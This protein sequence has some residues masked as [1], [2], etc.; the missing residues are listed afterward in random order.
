ML[1]LPSFAQLQSVQRDP[2]W[3]EVR[4]LKFASGDVVRVQ[5]VPE[6]GELSDEA[7][8]EMIRISNQKKEEHLGLITDQ[9]EM[10]RVESARRREEATYKAAEGIARATTGGVGL[11]LSAS[12][13]Q[14]VSKLYGT[15]QT[16][17]TLGG[18]ASAVRKSLSTGRTGAA[19]AT[20]VFHADAVSME[21]DGNKSTRLIS[22]VPAASRFVRG[23]GL[24]DNVNKIRE[25][26]SDV[27][28]S[29]ALEKELEDFG[30]SMTD[31]VNDYARKNVIANKWKIEQAEAELRRRRQAGD[32][33]SQDAGQSEAAGTDA[34]SSGLEPE[35]GESGVPP[36]S[37]SDDFASASESQ[38]AATVQEDLS[39]AEH[40]DG[41]LA[42][43][44][45]QPEDGDELN[46]T[47]TKGTSLEEDFGGEF[48][49]EREEGVL[50]DIGFEDAPHWVLIP[51]DEPD[52]GPF[53]PGE[54]YS[55]E[56]EL[57]PE[58]LEGAKIEG[59]FGDLV[60]EAV[61]ESAREELEGFEVVFD[62]LA[63]AEE[64]DDEAK[65]GQLR[66]F[67]ERIDADT[68]ARL[69]TIHEEVEKRVAETRAR[70][71]EQR[72]RMEAIQSIL[73]EVEKSAQNAGGQGAQTTSGDKCVTQRGLSDA[74]YGAFMAKLDAI[75][76]RAKKSR[77]VA[78]ALREQ[79]ALMRSY[80]GRS[81]CEQGK[82]Q[83]LNDAAMLEQQARRQ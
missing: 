78:R 31:G 39:V 29:I 81:Q 73:K 48:P 65:V 32:A 33:P 76:A 58:G 22:R 70:H 66:Q 69:A 34:S 61:Q 30:Q 83:F 56:E 71:Q 80:A 62:S 8:E 4:Y 9:I 13:N 59:Q 47:E 36:E 40:G 55:G 41:D 6:W 12:P 57:M 24:A 43:D 14:A 74:D 1:A 49:E 25:G 15:T 2:Q 11:L 18:D 38:Q 35:L 52:D 44:E 63:D 5:G 3:D 60:S 37:L 23:I 53:L 10:H 19:W 20:D 27:G 17:I 77:N 46:S 54:E 28:E 82:R 50:I 7:L 79:A 68:D 45:E 67:Y 21:L 75:G 16:A 42:M 26:V 51:I 72:E 64:D